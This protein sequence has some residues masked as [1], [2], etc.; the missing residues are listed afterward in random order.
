[1]TITVGA[2]NDAPVAVNDAATTTEEAPVSGNVLTN[3]TDVDAGTT[4][5][6]TLVANPANGS[7]TLAVE[8]QLHLHA[9]RELQRDRH[10]HLHGERRHGGLERR[11]G[12]DHGRRGQR[13][14]RG[15]RRQLRHGGRHAADDCGAW[16]ARQRHRRRTPRSLTAVVVSQPAS[17]SLTLNANGSFT[18]TP[19]ANFNG[20]DSFTYTA[21][22]GTSVSNV[23]TVTIAVNAVNDAPVAVN[24]AATTPEETAVSGNVLTNDTDVD[25]GTTLTATLVANASNGTAT[26]GSDGAFTYTPN[27]NFSGTDSF[28]YTA[29]DGT[30]I[31]NI[32]TVTITVT[33]V[34][35]API[36]VNDAAATD[37]R[38][39]GQR[40]RADQRHRRRRRHDADGDPG[41]E[42]GERVASRWPRTAPSPITPNAN[43]NGTTSSPTR[44]ATARRPR[45]SRRSRSP[46]EPSTTRRWRPTTA[47]PRRKTRC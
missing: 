8:R 29:S 42:P 43:F 5:T 32:A 19:N 22:D 45:M 13:C 39:A 33:A 17:G 16:S 34:N 7:V 40:E 12:D 2:V 3:D 21:R 25:A 38:R 28:T 44:R 11:D 20:T 15:G 27:A 1:M 35:D 26:L 31:S 47:T 36:A 24:D 4:L 46:S 9:E 10:V 6:A 37:G 30:A 23:A 14:A 41:G 18:Y